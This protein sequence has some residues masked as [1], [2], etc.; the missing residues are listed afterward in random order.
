MPCHIYIGFIVNDTQDLI[1]DLV[2]FHSQTV[3][4]KRLTVSLGFFSLINNEEALSKCPH[5]RLALVQAQYTLEKVKE[6][7]SGPAISQFLESPQIVSLCKKPELLESVEK[8]LWDIKRKY[9]PIL[10]ELLG[11]HVARLELA[12]YINLVVRCL[13]SKPWPAFEPKMTIPCGR[14]SK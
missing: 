12:V 1:Q 8:T 13:F 14:F 3:N 4:P 5:L 10:K 11:E 7:A 2:E 6:Q 9:Y